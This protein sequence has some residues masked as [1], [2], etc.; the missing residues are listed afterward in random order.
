M[1]RYLKRA[2]FM[3]LLLAAVA[4]SIL[5][6]GDLLR[7][8][9]L[10]TETQQTSTASSVSAISHFVDVHAHLDPADVEHSIDAALQAMPG[11]NAVKIVF[12]PPPFTAD[13]PARYDADLILPKLA[14]HATKLAVLGGGGTLNAMIHESVRSGDAGPEIRRRF[15]QQAEELLRAGAAGFGEM[16]AEHFQGATPYQSAPPDHPLFLLLADIAAEHGVP[17][18]LHMEAVSQPL[19]LPAQLKSP[20]NPPRLRANIA[21]FERLLAHNPRARIIWAHAGSDNTGDRTPELCRRLL[22]AHPNLYMELKIDP[23][24]PGKN[25]SLVNGAG[26]PIK[27][28]W[29]QLFQ[30]FP[31]RFVVGSDQHYPEPPRGP[32]RWQTV[33]L[34]LNQLPE[35]LRQR[36]A[37]DNAALLYSARPRVRGAPESTQ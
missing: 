25:S 3:M 16:A 30:D 32:Q 28:D 37:R 14:G 23:L 29:L 7:A 24:S 33:V 6:D 4:G 2:G 13:D 35:G 18:D 19:T 34:L 8:G 27:P 11:E 15:K 20:P 26:G 9:S 12:M 10:T 31:D 5:T 21:G 22:A 1:K 17:I 36:I